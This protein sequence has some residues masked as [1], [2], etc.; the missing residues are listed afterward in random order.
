MSLADEHVRPG[1]RWGI[2]LGVACCAT[3]YALVGY[4]YLRVFFDL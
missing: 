1:S 2:P 3:L 4:G